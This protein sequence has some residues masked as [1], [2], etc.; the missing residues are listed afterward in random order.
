MYSGVTPPIST[1]VPHAYAGINH[2]TTR[3]VRNSGEI[4]S[5]ETVSRSRKKRDPREPSPS[6]GVRMCTYVRWLQ[7]PRVEK[8]S[9]GHTR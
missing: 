3:N 1:H 4:V 8:R 2:T 5:V 6:D 7:A 9:T